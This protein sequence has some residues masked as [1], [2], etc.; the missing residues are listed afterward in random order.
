MS[1]KEQLFGSDTT[2]GHTG[3]EDQSNSHCISFLAS[4]PS[5]SLFHRIVARDEARIVSE[6]DTITL[7]S[8]CWFARFFVSLPYTSSAH[9]GV[10][11][12][13]S[14]HPAGGGL[15]RHAAS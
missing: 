7:I 4:M 14:L 15:A 3:K 8:F 10:F 5:I 12:S 2:A 6:D 9:C 13:S 11:A 1:W